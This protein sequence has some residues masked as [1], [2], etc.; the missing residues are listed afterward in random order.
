MSG[1]RDG[2]EILQ[3]S[4][5]SS[6]RFPRPSRITTGSHTHLISKETVDHPT[7]D[8][9]TPT[10]DGGNSSSKKEHSSET[11]RTLRFLTFKELLMLRIEI[12]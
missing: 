10:Q 12:S 5:G 1:S 4:S 8:V 9:P 3:P 11:S 7:L 2:E 6:M